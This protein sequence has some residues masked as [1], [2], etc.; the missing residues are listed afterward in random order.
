M[1]CDI[2]VSFLSGKGL[3][4]DYLVVHAD[5]RPLGAGP[6]AGVVLEGHLAVRRVALLGQA[7]GFKDG[8][9]QLIAPSRWQVGPQHT[10]TTCSPGGVKRKLV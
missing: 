8:L 2:G 5:H 9:Q 6:Q 4:P 3:G 7:K 10:S 1:L